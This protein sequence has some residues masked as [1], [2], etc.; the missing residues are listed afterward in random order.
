[1]K[2]SWAFLLQSPV[3]L[4]ILAHNSAALY[5]VS[6]IDSLGR[7]VLAS[8]DV[9]LRKEWIEG[10]WWVLHASMGAPYRYKP[11]Q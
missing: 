1:M 2:R 10:A 11:F 3:F 6:W 7:N 8:T 9:V 4:H 5:S